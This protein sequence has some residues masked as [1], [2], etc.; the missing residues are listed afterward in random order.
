MVVDGEG[1]LE[2]RPPENGF[3]EGED[4]KSEFVERPPTEEDLALVQA[5]SLFCRSDEKKEDRLGQYGHN[6]ISTLLTT[7]YSPTSSPTSQRSSS[8]RLHSNR[9]ISWTQITLFHRVRPR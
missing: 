9:S 7:I 8:L 6:R 3:G 1:L 5:A 4:P 2:L